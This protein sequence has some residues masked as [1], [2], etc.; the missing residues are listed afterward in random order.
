MSQCTNLCFRGISISLEWIPGHCDI[1][2]NEIADKAAK[3][4]IQNLD[5]DI[6]NKLNKSE[7]N[8]VLNHYYDQKWQALWEETNSPLKILQP[9]V[10]KT[11]KSFI[12]NK[13][14]EQIIHC[15]RMGNIGL[16]ENLHKVNRHETGLCDSCKIPETIEHF[17]CHCQRYIITRAMMIAE[18]DTHEENILNLL[19]SQNVFQQRAL[20]NF[21]DRSQRF[22]PLNIG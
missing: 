2:G 11:Y 4:A 22:S 8:Y 21:V 3:Q 20:V 14:G 5:I 12:K 9:K 13:R 19:T 17:L 10:H 1:I 16:N 15:L 18:A 6:K 7:F